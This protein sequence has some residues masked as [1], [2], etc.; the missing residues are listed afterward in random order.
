MIPTDSLDFLF[1]SVRQ[2][3]IGIDGSKILFANPAA[4]SVLGADICA[5]KANDLI[6]SDILDNQSDSFACAAQISGHNV[7]INALRNNGIL[8]LFVDFIR[9]EKSA[10]FITRHIINNLRNCAM[11]I[12]MSADK[13]FS[14]L[15]DGNTPDEK[16]ISILYHYY[17][18]LVRSLTQVDSADLLERGEMIFSPVRTDLVKLCGELTD[19]VSKLC[20][21]KGIN[22]SFSTTENELFAVIDPSKIEHLLLNLF[23]NSLGNTPPGGSIELSLQQAGHRLILSMDDNGTGIPQEVLSNVFT[24]P[25][26]DFDLSGLQ[27]GN[28]LGLYIASGI[29]QLHKGVLL[30][31]SREGGGTRIRVMLPTDENPAPKFN[32]PETPYRHSG[33]SSILTGLADILS[34]DCFGVKFED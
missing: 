12:K 21:E 19:T 30:I 5:R 32:C 31:D 33:V 16:H 1:S 22:I 14:Y 28:G 3:V 34:N 26:E 18:S 20:D 2:A 6:P 8:L 24:L 13:C 23:S 7:G 17:Y 11:G 10:L 27:S 9:T 25:N 29:A 15:E 4:K